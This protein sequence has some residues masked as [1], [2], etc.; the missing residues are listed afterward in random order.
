MY[1]VR[2]H[3]LMVSIIFSPYAGPEKKF[4]KYRIGPDY[5]ISYTVQNVSS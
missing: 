4:P 3:K 1:I 5:S 2:E